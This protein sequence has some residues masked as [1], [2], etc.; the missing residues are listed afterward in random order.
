MDIDADSSKDPS[1]IPEC[2][3]DLADVFSKKEAISLSPLRDHLDHHISL[4]KDAKSIFDLIYNLSENELKVLKK[5]LEDKLFKGLIHPSISSFDSPVL[6]VKKSDGNLRLCV[7][8]RAL[9][10]MTIKN[11]Y[12]I[13]LITEIMDRIRNAKEFTRVDIRDIFH[14]ICI[15]EGD[16]YKTAFRIRY[17]HFEY[18]IMPFDL[19]NAPAIFQSYINDVLR[20]FLDEFCVVYLDDV[21]IYTDD[22]HEEHVQ[23]VRQIL[24]RLLDHDLYANLR[25]AN[26]MSE[27]LN[28]LVL[29]SLPTA[30]QWIQNAL[31]SLSI[32]QSPTLN[33]ISEYSSALPISID[34]LY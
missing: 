5:Y 32:G 19:C 4:E 9:N 26:F 24:Q 16:E 34:A 29:S 15:A 14:R 18:L 1:E 30:S 12:S 2:Y 6:F 3:R 7:D 10:R 21:L 22:T 11:R 17:D 28:S 20:E 8:Y 33:M 13:P 25:S 31:S 27:K 23:H